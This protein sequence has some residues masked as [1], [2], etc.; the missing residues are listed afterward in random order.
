MSLPSKDLEELKQD[1]DKYAYQL[2]RSSNKDEALEIAIKAAETSMQALKLAQDPD[3]KAKL[4]TRVKQLLKEAET[5]K[6]SRDWRTAIGSSS[7]STQRDN[8][9]GNDTTVTSSKTRVLKEPQSTRKLP[10]SEQILLLKAG[11]LNGFKFPPWTIPPDP[12]EF[13]LNHGEDMFLYVSLTLLL[14]PLRLTVSLN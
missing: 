11:F 3:E 9:N 6:S 8:G 13:E 5:I 1:A 14:Q 10:K 2:P 7:P 12:G 4:S